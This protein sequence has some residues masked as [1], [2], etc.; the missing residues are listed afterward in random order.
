MVKTII[1]LVRGLA[2]TH[3]LIRSFRYDS[4]GKAAGTGEDDVPLVFLEM[5]IYYGDVGVMQG[6]IPCTFNVDIVL[7]PQALENFDV[8]QL[9]PESCQEIASQVAQQFV[10]RMRNLYRDGDSTVSV[11]SYSILTLQRWYDDSSYGVR[12]TVDCTVVNEIG[13]CVDDDYFDSGKTFDNSSLLPDIDTDGATGCVSL[14]YKLSNIP[15]D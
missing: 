11:L 14:S 1:D 4:L 13:F 9:T 2:E 15:L 5:P 7:N 12:L 8:E 10:A 6:V 3:K